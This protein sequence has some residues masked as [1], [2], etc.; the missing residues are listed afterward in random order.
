MRVRGN[1]DHF[2]DSIKSRRGLHRRLV[3]FVTVLFLLN[4]LITG[5]VSRVYS[6]GYQDLKMTAELSAA[7]IKKQEEAAKLTRESYS[8]D[9]FREISERIQTRGTLPV[10]VRL[11]ASFVPEGE[12]RGPAEARA[13]RMVIA[14]A[15][16][17][18]VD[19]L[20]GYDPGSVKS[21]ES[22]PFIAVTVNATGV[23]A[24]RA[25]GNVLD[26]EEDV[27]MR[28]SLAQS[29]PL[30]GA[31]SAWA[32]GYTGSGQV[33]A[34]LDT[35]VDKNHPFL[36]GKVV[37][38]ACYSTTATSQGAASVCPGGS[39]SSTVVDSGLP[40]SVSGDCDHGT[41]VAGIAAGK[42]SS[43]S[44]VAKDASVIAIQV[45]TRFNNAD[46]CGGTAPCAMAF[47]SDIVKGLQRVYELRSTYNIASA[48]LSLG[49]DKSTSNCD[50]SNAATKA[51]IDLLRGAGIATVIASGNES[52]T[53]A[54]GSP[55]CISTAI[56]VGSV[57]DSTATV[58]SFSN[59]ASFL[60]LLAP[61]GGITSSVPGTGFETWSGTSMATPHVTGAWAIMKQK[62]PTA[63]VTQVL[64]AFTS[65]GQAIN[66]SR[67]NIVKPLIKV[68]LAVN[69]LGNAG[70]PPSIP[71]APTGLTATVSQTN[72]VSLSWTDNSSNESGFRI[73]RKTGTTGTAAIVATASQNVT[74]YVNTT[75]SGSTDYY[76][77]V[78]AYNS[79]GESPASNEF[80]VTTLSLPTVPSNL[81]ATVDSATSISL[82]W[83]DTS[84][85][86]NGFRIRRRTSQT[87]FW[88][89]LAVVGPN[90]STYLNT[91]LTTGRTY[92]YS[93]TAY[94]QTGESALSNQASATTTQTSPPAA[95]TELS[96]TAST[97]TVNLTW[98]DN[99]NNEAGFR[100]SRKTGATGSW[101]VVGNVAQDVRSV[102]NVGLTSGVTYSYRV[103]SYNTA[104]ESASSNE[105]TVTTLSN[106]PVAPSNLTATVVS[107]SQINLQ[108]V[109]T[110]GNETGFRISRKIGYN[111]TW[112]MVATVGQNV[113]TFE[114]TG[115]TAGSTYFYLVTSYNS[116]GESG[117]SNEATATTPASGGGG[118]SAPSGLQA[119]ASTTN[120]INLAWV[121]ASNNETGFQIQR[122]K[123]DTWST[124]ATVGANVTTY[125]NSGLSPGTFYT[126]QIVAIN[127]SN[128]SLASNQVTVK[129]PT[130][131]F[132]TIVNGQVIT[133]TVI[134]GSSKYYKL[135]LPP[136]VTQVSVATTGSGDLDLYLSSYSQ[137]TR[138]VFNCRSVSSTSSERC[139]INTPGS[140]DWH[141]MV[142]GY[143]A[144]ISTYS[145]TVTVQGGGAANVRSLTEDGEAAEPAILPR[146]DASEAPD[147]P[148][149]GKLVEEEDSAI[150]P[151]RRQATI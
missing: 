83:S 37:S 49:G 128:S 134:K 135:Y 93:V 77:Y 102:Q 4:I 95:P 150:L 63:T 68:D 36:A 133:S 117:A 145:L 89:L 78:V 50:S 58:S 48:N 87:G 34:I 101:I 136:G 127:G 85:N 20:V 141:I 88:T 67:N 126:Y 69:S 13:Q 65:T 76:Y 41:H 112:S 43:F 108:W 142:Y 8:I 122:K 119:T 1:F 39:S 114:N 138:S 130:N 2:R 143:G 11:R 10:I 54:L 75:V 12:I 30:I 18:L 90:V 5:F 137:P 124:I 144:T 40:C 146:R 149:E 60:S 16:E 14:S 55:A 38:E 56:S 140:G 15:R 97:N 86:E 116:S 17:R 28:A 21:F 25:S 73:Y 7:L 92:Y 29:V 84:D 120:L 147:A 96:A 113:T 129:T 118:P 131:S 80:K 115:L 53:N 47:T 6:A 132:N 111:G 110:S 42:G 74:T 51:A 45:F 123:D 32:S 139:V 19:E 27:L 26:I 9:H 121:D 106:I 57:S 23:E 72:Q 105:V 61:G 148:E 52:Y 24:L 94:N 82:S 71:V 59:S 35:G 64:D 109:D 66:D 103:T 62:L 79:A 81:T 98:T 33:V 104:G 91:G 125:F 100:I 151:R 31:D 46:S 3:M 107:T 70:P 22:L 44:G 99:S